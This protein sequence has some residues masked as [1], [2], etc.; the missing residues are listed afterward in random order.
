MNSAFRIPNSEFRILNCELCLANR[1]GFEYNSTGK[2]YPF[3]KPHFIDCEGCY[4]M[5]V[6]LQNLTK[7][8]PNMN[9]KLDD[10][11]AV[12]DFSFEIPDGKLIGLLGPS[13]C[14]KST[15][16][17]LICGLEKPTSG[18]IFFGEDDV[19]D[20]PPENRGVGLVFQNYALYPHMTVR[21]N[22][23]FP[24]QN[25]KGKD[26]LPKV[27]MLKRAEAAAKLVQI[28]QLMDRKPAEMS[29]G[30]QQRVAIA[31]ALVKMPRVL[32][33]DE[34]LS[35]LDA[36][37]RLQTREEIRRIQRNTG[38]T[39]IFV[40]HDQEEAMSISDLIVVMKDGIIQQIDQPQK[41]YDDPKNLFVAKFL[42][43]PPINVFKGK[44]AAG[45]L[46]LGE[47]AVLQVQGVA[48]QELWVGVRPEGFVPQ[49]AG[50][51]RCS[52]KA[53]EVMGRDTSVVLGNETAVSD[54]LRAI[55]SSEYQ[56][57]PG[58]DEIRFALKP[59]KVFLFDLKTEE[60]IPFQ[61]E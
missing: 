23:M 25:L 51:L 20:L 7:K 48:D 53:V 39:T 41:V 1:S 33:L 50:P 2:L 61:A 35:N 15:T 42:G 24:L 47:D 31:R 57:A 13:G 19:T 17:N 26:K 4:T 3:V 55:I 21:Q 40:T 45:K 5:K 37:L 9:K 43:T 59:N 52:L 29:G 10:V 16:L 49:Q 12:N 30:Q 6:V 38:I 56:V 32:L 8:F 44:V 60:R 22:I 58:T 11:I 46:Y 34:P 14:G 36:R 27:E 28:D 54:P 18:K